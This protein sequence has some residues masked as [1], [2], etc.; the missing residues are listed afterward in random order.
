MKKPATN[1]ELDNRCINL[2]L[3][4]H[5][6]RRSWPKMLSAVPWCRS[7][8]PCSAPGVVDFSSC[9]NTMG[10][11]S[12]SVSSD[13][14]NDICADATGDGSEASQAFEGSYSDTVS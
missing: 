9:S 14:G 11:G 13:T 2:N 7:K 4:Q 3:H 1:W 6:K 8:H 5:G 12:C 10:Y